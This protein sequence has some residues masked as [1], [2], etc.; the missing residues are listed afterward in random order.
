M[1]E[2]ERNGFSRIGKYGEALKCFDKCISINQYYTNAWNNKGLLLENIGRYGEAIKCYDK[3]ISIDMNNIFG[4]F[5][6]AILMK[7]RRNFEESLECI[8]HFIQIGGEEKMKG[9]EVKVELL[10]Q[11]KKWVELVLVMDDNQEILKNKWGQE[12][13]ATAL[14]NLEKEMEEKKEESLC[15]FVMSR[16]L[17]W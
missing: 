9:I 3:C 1:L 16:K 10:F 11:M 8:E 5:N 4:W 7:K 6:K 14:K 12:T 15:L 17:F 2:E 13:R